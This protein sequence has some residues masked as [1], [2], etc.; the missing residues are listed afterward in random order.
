M[1]D[2]D[3]YVSVLVPKKH[4]T[5]IYAFLGSLEEQILAPEAPKEAAQNGKGAGWT[6]ELIERQY[7]EASPF[8]KRFEQ[9]LAANPGQ[10]FSTREM[11]TALNAERGWNSVAGA[12]GAAL[13]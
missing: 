3:E 6:L 5:R 11:A 4:L 8:M 9:H 10:E 7:R 12:L 1:A 13:R 2:T